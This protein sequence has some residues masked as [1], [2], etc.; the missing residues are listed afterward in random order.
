MAKNTEVTF[1]IGLV[2]KEI[3]ILK[4]RLEVA[5]TEDDKSFVQSRINNRLEELKMLKG[6]EATQSEQVEQ[7]E[8][9]ALLSDL[10]KHQTYGIVGKTVKLVNDVY[11]FT[12]KRLKKAGE[13]GTLESINH[14]YDNGIVKIGKRKFTVSFR[15]IEV[16]I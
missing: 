5:Q 9:T 2:E 16:S 10:K 1:Y 8:E 11:G 7:V 13:I 15:D 14:F 12:G 3:E 6:I 4:G